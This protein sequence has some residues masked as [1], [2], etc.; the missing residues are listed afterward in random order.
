[1]SVVKRRVKMTESCLQE[2]TLLRWFHLTE[3]CGLSSLYWP[4]G[5]NRNTTSNML[6]W[7]KTTRLGIPETVLH[8][9]RNKDLL[10]LLTTIFSWEIIHYT[11][12]VWCLVFFMKTSFH[13]AGLFHCFDRKDLAFKLQKYIIHPE[14]SST[15]PLR[16]W[17]VENFLSYLAWLSESNGPSF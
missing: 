10:I 12:K 16:A 5:I 1:M 2:F 7:T 17:W 9:N 6:N 11:F 15:S 3:V 4:A 13:P 14:T 8:V